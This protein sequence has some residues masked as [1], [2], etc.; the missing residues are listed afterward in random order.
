M[1][2]N[3]LSR[4]ILTLIALSVSLDSLAP[5]GVAQQ[6]VKGCQ[7][8]PTNSIWNK[9]IDSLPVDTN[10]DKFVNT[11]GRNTHF[12]PDVGS[13]INSF[14]IPYNVVPAN[15]P[16]RT[17]NF[18]YAGESDSGPYPINGQLMIEGGTWAAS[19]SGDRHVL[20]VDT[21]NAILYELFNTSES[22]NGF[23]AGSGAIFLLT[24]NKLRSNGWTSADAAGLPV[25]PG[26][27]NYDEV[28]SG[29]V[30]HA[31]RFT[32]RHTNGYIWP[33]RHKAG[34]QINGYPPNGARFRLKQSINLASY[35]KS[36]QI[37]L[38]ALKEYGM[39]VADNGS[40]WFM[41]GAPDKRWNDAD[42]N[43][44]KRLT[45][46]D[47]EAVDEKALMVDPDSG[48]SK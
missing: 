41:S 2:C 13:D 29:A 20:M 23:H 27:L 35:S 4:S 30:R 34:P 28:A 18:E 17:V 48:Q 3:R 31:L 5:A 11:I 16:K 39:F 33:A 45:G 44:L 32:C 24:S 40:D 12:H 36:N 37:I 14:G 42:L 47:F 22:A 43:Q 46:N 6:V 1:F 10:S 7:I 26:L 9:R 8:F 19:K 38:T 21:T 25:F 15:M